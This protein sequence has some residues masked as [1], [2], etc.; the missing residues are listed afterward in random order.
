MEVKMEAMQE[1]TDANLNKMKASQEHLKEEIMVEMKVQIDVLISPMDTQLEGTK[2]CWEAMDSRI[3][4]GQE[5]ME[6]KIKTGL[7][8]MKPIADH[9]EVPKEAAVETIGALDN[10]YG[11]QGITIR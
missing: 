11:N 6:A 8:E 9:Q 1:K 3:G 4:M 2:D 10:R 7:K 5:H